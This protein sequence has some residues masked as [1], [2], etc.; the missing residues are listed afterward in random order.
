MYA[1]R[2]ILSKIHETI[3]Q[4]KRINLKKFYCL[5]N[6]LIMYLHIYYLLKNN[7]N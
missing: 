5:F 7:I 3:L 1:L 4:I 6:Y 2:S